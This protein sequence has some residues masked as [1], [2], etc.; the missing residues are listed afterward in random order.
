MCNYRKGCCIWCQSS[1][2]IRLSNEAAAWRTRIHRFL[3]R[4]CYAIRMAYWLPYLLSFWQLWTTLFF[5]VA[6]IAYIEFLI[7]VTQSAQGNQLCTIE[8]TTSDSRPCS[9]IVQKSPAILTIVNFSWRVKAK[10][11][12]AHNSVTRT[13]NIVCTSRVDSNH[14]RYTT[15]ERSSVFSVRRDL[16]SRISVG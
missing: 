5:W 9:L 2:A 6:L 12:N 13:E 3:L 14:S 11:Q 16:E 7:G 4:G 10:T 8:I 15:P 1:C